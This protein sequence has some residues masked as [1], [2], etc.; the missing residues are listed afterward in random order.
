MCAVPWEK[1]RGEPLFCKEF[2][3]FIDCLHELV[4]LGFL[5]DVPLLDKKAVSAVIRVEVAVVNHVEPADKATLG[6]A[7]V[8]VGTVAPSRGEPRTAEACATVADTA[9][10]GGSPDGGTFRKLMLGYFR[11]EFRKDIFPVLFELHCVSLCR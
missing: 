8:A 3:N 10:A 11:N 7:L 4:K 1:G 6:S 2:L 5:K 9:V